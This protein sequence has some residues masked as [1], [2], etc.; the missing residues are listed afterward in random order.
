M[1][2][3]N[4]IVTVCALLTCL[5]N[6]QAQTEFTENVDQVM[7]DANR[8]VNFKGTI[9]IANSAGVIYQSSIGFA[10]KKEE[11]L[12]T[13][14]HRFAP[15]SIIKEFTTV[16]LMRLETKGKINYHDKITKYLNDLP[17]WVN[18]ITIEHL[19]THTSGLGEMNYIEGIETV[20]VV[21]QIKAVKN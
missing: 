12:L 5:T 17:A 16:A 13:N 8:I 18:D 19:L 15:G 21:E 20:D 3:L 4:S 10:D 9:L 2:L 7:T 14:E 1:N 6:V 11:M